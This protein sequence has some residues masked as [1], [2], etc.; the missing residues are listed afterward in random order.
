MTVRFRPTKPALR[1]NWPAITTVACAAIGG[2][3]IGA[4]ITQGVMLTAF[5]GQGVPTCTDAIADAGGTCQG[6][7]EWVTPASLPDPLPLDVTLP[8]CEYED[9][10]AD[11]SPCFW[12]GDGASGNGVGLSYVVI[13]GA[14]YYL[15]SV[16]K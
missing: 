12:D 10:S 16:T 9:G 3:I 4:A 6:I 8:L 15:P 11:G 5:Q 14:F 2:A 7:P 13:D 1:Y